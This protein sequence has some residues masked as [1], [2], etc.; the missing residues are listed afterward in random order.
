MRAA[1][2]T[3]VEVFEW[4]SAEA[5]ANAHSNP[6]VQAMWGRYSAACEYVPLTSIKECS[7]LFA[8]FEPV[9]L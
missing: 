6:A 1:D 3:I 5:I 9:E 7:D 2:G 8:Q 4:K